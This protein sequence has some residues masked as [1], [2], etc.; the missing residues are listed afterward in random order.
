MHYNYQCLIYKEDNVTVN[1]IARVLLFC[2]CCSQLFFSSIC[3]KQGMV[4]KWKTVTDVFPEDQKIDWLN[5]LQ[6]SFKIHS[7]KKK[8]KNKPSEVGDANI[9]NATTL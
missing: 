1:F 9:K 8:N 7:Q 3:L 5:S 4:V 2:C 6:F